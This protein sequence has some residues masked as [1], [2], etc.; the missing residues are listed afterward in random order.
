MGFQ[1]AMVRCLA[2]LL[3]YVSGDDGLK[4]RLGDPGSVHPALVY[5]LE[6]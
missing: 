1:I 2:I 3:S 5:G 6:E 4:N